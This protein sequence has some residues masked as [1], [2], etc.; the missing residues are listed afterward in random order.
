MR[1]ADKFS[2]S[3]QAGLMFMFM[4]M[5]LL[6]TKQTALTYIHAVTNGKTPWISKY[7][8][9]RVTKRKVLVR[10]LVNILVVNVSSGS[11]V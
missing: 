5:L 8:L 9:S 7:F 1:A 6:S 2:H 3:K 11:L 10:M 4:F